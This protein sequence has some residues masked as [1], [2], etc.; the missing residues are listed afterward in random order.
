MI[1]QVLRL[2]QA[3]QRFSEE[4][5]Q[6]NLSQAAVTTGISEAFETITNLLEASL[7]TAGHK[8]ADMERR[9]AYTTPMLNV[10]IEK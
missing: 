6:L 2:D 8:Y 5:I 4:T 9:Y 3:L 1:S 7:A 10:L